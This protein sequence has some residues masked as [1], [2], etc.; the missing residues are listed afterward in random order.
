MIVTS[1]GPHETNSCFFYENSDGHERMNE[2]ESRLIVII[3]PQSS[4][5]SVA[6]S[7]SRSFVMHPSFPDS[8][9]HHVPL[10]LCRP[11]VRFV[12]LVGLKERNQ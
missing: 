4:V 6:L 1:H 12:S 8:R 7:K 9:D 2:A 5:L 10:I 11:C 3:H